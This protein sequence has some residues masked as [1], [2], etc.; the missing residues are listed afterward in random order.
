MS[1]I[2]SSPRSRE[3]NKHESVSAREIADVIPLQIVD[4]ASSTRSAQI[5]LFSL[6]H[7]EESRHDTMFA[8]T[9]AVHELSPSSQTTKA[10]SCFG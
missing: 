8:D 1:L 10:H 9:K 4:T 2:S 5:G 7:D 3:R 6:R